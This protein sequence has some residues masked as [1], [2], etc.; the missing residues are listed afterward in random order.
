MWRFSAG[1]IE[2]LVSDLQ[3]E[4]DASVGHGVC[5]TQNPTAH[6]GIAEIEDGHAKRGLPFKL[7]K[8]KYK[9]C[10]V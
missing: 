5:Q 1:E 2:K 10:E 7:T 4:D 3:K 6:D 8:W 9:M